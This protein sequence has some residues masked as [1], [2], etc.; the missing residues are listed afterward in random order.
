MRVRLVAI[1]NPRLS[2]PAVALV[3]IRC[4]AHHSSCLD[5]RTVIPCHM[6]TP[7][8]A[9][10]H[11]FTQL[12][13]KHEHMAC[14]LQC[15]CQGALTFVLLPH[16]TC[17]KPQRICPRVDAISQIFAYKWR[18]H[19]GT[20]RSIGPSRAC[21]QFFFFA[22]VIYGKRQRPKP[23]PSDRWIA[24]FLPRLTPGSPHFV[25]S[26]DSCLVQL[27]DCLVPGRV[28]LYSRQAT[29]LFTGQAG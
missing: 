7:M 25:I 21:F 29:T 18:Y 5:W 6:Y 28:R 24:C 12:C 11:Y 17:R 15:S 16:R 23:A 4:A 10:I 20:D 1:S 27:L 26:P 8:C 22:V 3:L 13:V 14:R 9:P 19:S 2:P